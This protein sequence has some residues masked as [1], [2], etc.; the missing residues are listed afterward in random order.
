M[1]KILIL[2][3][4][5][6]LGQALIEQFENSYEVIP[7]DKEDIDVNQKEETREKIVKI[8]PDIIINAT[9]I[10]AVDKIEEDDVTFQLAQNINGFVVGELAKITKELG[11]IFVHYSTD[12]IFDGEKGRAYIETDGANPISKYAETKLLGEKLT[13]EKGEKFYIIRL[14]RLFGKAGSSEMSKR[15]FVDTMLAAAQ[16]K[17]YLEVIDDQYASPTY[18]PDLANFTRRLLEEFR[19]YGIYHGTNAGGC[20]WYEWA[21]KIFEIRNMSVDLRPVSVMKFPRPAK[22]PKYSVLENT[23]MPFQRTWE[24]ALKEYLAS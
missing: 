17:D 6:T 3:A 2:G 15:S 11:S 9:A 24:D 22:A 16:E 4:K 21:K 12:Y 18:A 14:S 8:R 1:K 5:G 7:L 19:P 23:K 10:N 20:T 13:Q